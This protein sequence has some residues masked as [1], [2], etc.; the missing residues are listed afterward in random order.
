MELED[1]GLVRRLAEA[2]RSAL[3]KYTDDVSFAVAGD[4]VGSSLASNLGWTDCT[5]IRL[6][7]TSGEL[8]G[9]LCLADRGAAP[10][11]AD[12]QLMR[13]IAGHAGIALENARLF[14]R[15]EQANRHWVEIFDSISDFIVVHDEHHN[16]L[17]VNRS[18]AELIGLEPEQ[19]IGINMRALDA[20]TTGSAPHSCPF[21]RS[22]EGLDEYVHPALE[23][24]YL[25]TTSR[26]HSAT[27]EPGHDRVGDR[28]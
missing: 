5:L 13:A 28:E 3:P 23:R 19:L 7:G 16:I 12:Y 15:M 26:I 9:G 6:A 8:V 18:L 17:R 25:V 20:L 24:I 1:K 4:L 11:D 22:G 27:P 2:L 14:T 21:C 10:S